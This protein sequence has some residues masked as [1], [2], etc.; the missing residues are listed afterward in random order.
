L[1]ELILP[2]AEA[3]ELRRIQ[4]LFSS[5]RERAALALAERIERLSL[6]AVYK[7][8]AIPGIRS[9][10]LGCIVHQPQHAGVD[11]AVLCLKER[12]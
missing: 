6:F 5:E 4:T 9:S 1:K 8:D 10:R 3:E 2:A 11:L 12:D 7:R